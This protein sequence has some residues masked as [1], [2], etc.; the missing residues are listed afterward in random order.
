VVPAAPHRAVLAEA[1]VVV[2]HAGHGTVMKSLAA[3]VPMVCI[4]MGRDQ[5]DNAAR[6]LELGAGVRIDKRSTPDRIAAAVSEVMDHADYG[7]AARHFSHVLAEEAR[8]G[9]HA[10]DEAEALLDERRP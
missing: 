9:P 10:A 3:G 5:K 7:A 1:S 8:R 2:T 6:V 4:P